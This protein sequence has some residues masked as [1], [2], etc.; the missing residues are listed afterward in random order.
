V[1]WLF[2]F[3]CAAHNLSKAAQADRTKTCGKVPGELRLKPPQSL[4]RLFRGTQKARQ[5]K[6]KL[7]LEQTST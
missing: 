6:T 1:D 5:R 3:S 7:S 2:V 4:K